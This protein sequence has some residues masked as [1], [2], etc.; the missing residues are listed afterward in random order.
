MPHPTFQP[1]EVAVIGGGLG[2]YLTKPLSCI[3]L[4]I[5]T[6]GLSAAISLRRQGHIVTI[7]ERYDF[8]GEVGAS[9]S[10]AANG[11]QHL[12]E[13]GVSYTSPL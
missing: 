8:N 9:I 7:Y 4:I 12:V 1:L 13:W 3:K 6:G 10:C 11:T 2:K 5:K